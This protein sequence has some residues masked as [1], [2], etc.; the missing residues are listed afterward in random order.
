[1]RV[2]G[3]G[4]GRLGNRLAGRERLLQVLSPWGPQLDMALPGLTSVVTD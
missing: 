4:W 3:E 1:M 2:P